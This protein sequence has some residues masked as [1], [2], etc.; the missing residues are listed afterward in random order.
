VN[1]KTGLVGFLDEVADRE[2][3]ARVA[4][5]YQVVFNGTADRLGCLGGTN[6]EMAVT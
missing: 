2:T 1:Q 6:I 4:N 3:A 5:V